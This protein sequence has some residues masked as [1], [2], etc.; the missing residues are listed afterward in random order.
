M[1]KFCHN[2]TTLLAYL[3]EYFNMD[4]NHLVVNCLDNSNTYE[5]ISDRKTQEEI[6]SKLLY[7][8]VLEKEQN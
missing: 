3:N 2:D 5:D 6:A 8:L 4:T 7:N 1:N